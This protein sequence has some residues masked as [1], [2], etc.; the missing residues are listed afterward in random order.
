MPLLIVVNQDWILFFIVVHV[1]DLS[2]QFKT[3]V[4]DCPLG[5]DRDFLNK[6]NLFI[7]IADVS[8]QYKMSLKTHT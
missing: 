8:F 7:T 2:R 6:L 5:G 1:S 4:S 3:P